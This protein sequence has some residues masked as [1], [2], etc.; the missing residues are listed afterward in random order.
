MCHPAGKHRKSIFS[1][2]FLRRGACYPA[3]LVTVCVSKQRKRKQ[4]TAR[5][6]SPT[7]LCVLMKTSVSPVAYVTSLLVSYLS[8][9]S[10]SC[11]KTTSR[12]PVCAGGP[13][14]LPPCRPW[15]S[16]LP[17]LLRPGRL[18][19][20][21]AAPRPRSPPDARRRRPHFFLSPTHLSCPLPDSGNL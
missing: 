18:P 12:P 9:S 4:V 15:V 19:P 5:R 8:G 1:P 2:A 10:P 21:P 3:P 7:Q 20:P 14:P 17:E 16:P 6:L 13:R 11:F